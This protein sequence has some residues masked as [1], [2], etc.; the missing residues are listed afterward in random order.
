MRKLTVERAL[1]GF[2]LVVCAVFFI[3]SLKLRFGNLSLPGPGFFP[4]L[5]GA[6]GTLLSLWIFVGTLRRRPGEGDDEPIPEATKQNFL[7]LGLFIGTIVVFLL[8]FKDFG[9]VVL[10]LFT[11]V[12][13]KIF[14]FRGWLRVTIMA[15]IVAAGIY[16][17]FKRLLGV[18]LPFGLI[19]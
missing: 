18:P 5:L 9:I 13:G 8:L 19:F 2:F 11:W 1:S 4:T 16:L 6:L 3:L 7:R 10:F 12:M 17:V 14:G 15:A